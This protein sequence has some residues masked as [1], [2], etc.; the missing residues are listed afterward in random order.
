MQLTQCVAVVQFGVAS[1]SCAEVKIAPNVTKCVNMRTAA[2]SDIRYTS[3][4]FMM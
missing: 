1:Y 4:M 2:E 3:K